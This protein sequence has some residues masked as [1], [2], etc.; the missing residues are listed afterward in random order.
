MIG[1]KLD[2]CYLVSFVQTKECQ[3]Q[4]DKIV[5]VTLGFQ[6]PS[7]KRFLIHVSFFENRRK[8]LFGGGLAIGSSDGQHFRAVYLAPVMRQIAEGS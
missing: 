7:S 8:H 1:A 3:G 4:A 5:E 6:K 2:D